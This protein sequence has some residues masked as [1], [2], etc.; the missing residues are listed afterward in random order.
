MHDAVVATEAGR[1]T[2]SFMT[3]ARSRYTR[4]LARGRLIGGYLNQP[5]RILLAE[6]DADL[7]SAAATALREDGHEV[8]EVQ[9]GGRLLVRI[10]GAYSEHTREVAY[11]VIVSDIRMPV[12]SGIQILENVRKAHWTIP[13]ILMTAFGNET[14][15]MHVESLGAIL[16]DKPFGLDEL[17]NAVTY[18]L[19]GQGYD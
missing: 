10:A 3:V 7:R 13:V 11:D 6:D 17:R 2:S 18:L 1:S 16:L 8:I 9:D 5:R 14:T 12:C 15:R 4:A 19:P